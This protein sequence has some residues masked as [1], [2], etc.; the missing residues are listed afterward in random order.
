M[1]ISLYNSQNNNLINKNTKA[2]LNKHNF[3]CYERISFTGMKSPD[4]I[5]TAIAKF[6]DE[7]S[8]KFFPTMEDIVLLSRRHPE[9]AGRAGSIPWRTKDQIGVFDGF[10]NAAK[11]LRETYD[12]DTASKI[13]TDAMKK[14]KIIPSKTSISLESLGGG[15]LGNAY[16]FSV[17]GEEYV[18]KVF[19]HT[20]PS[21]TFVNLRDSAIKLTEGNVFGV[22]G[23]A[24]KGINAI[25]HDLRQIGDDVINRRI[26]PK[27][28]DAFLRETSHGVHF[29]A[30]RA[31]RI[32]RIGPQG[33]QFEKARIYFA[34]LESG[35]TVN[36][37][38]PENA[39]TPTNPINLRSHGLTSTDSGQLTLSGRRIEHN[40][41]N[42]NSFDFGGLV[43]RHG[44]LSN[45]PKAIE[46]YGRIV[47]TR[48][49]DRAAAWI[50]EFRLAQGDP[51][52][53]K[54]L[55]YAIEQVPIPGRLA[56]TREIGLLRSGRQ[57]IIPKLPRAA[58]QRNYS[59]ENVARG[60]DKIKERKAFIEEIAGRVLGKKIE[61]PIPIADSKLS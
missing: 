55:A 1:L 7:L 38:V 30:N 33:N 41:T 56:I 40:I 49:P 5:L 2:K 3:N 61:L 52:K 24:F 47:S 13:L 26:L 34:D 20:S 54:G 50:N 43:V 18:L 42:G 23:N 48:E 9:A 45:S 59:A 19:R 21:E 4:T 15:A 22:L 36:K 17:G 57:A 6:T 28:L 46:V 37:F 16:K 31:S 32:G 8:S 12:T 58:L 10:A 29:E 53:I 14:A 35:F 60:Q 27:A 39:P 11:N 51:E 44:A 25:S